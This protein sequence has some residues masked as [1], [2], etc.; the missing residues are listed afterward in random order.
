MNYGD[1]SV[2]VLNYLTAFGSSAFPLPSAGPS[3]K[4]SL[5]FSPGPHLSSTFAHR[6]HTISISF[7]GVIK[8]HGGGHQ[9]S[10]VLLDLDD[11]EP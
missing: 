8:R 7:T 5:G 3:G 1:F 4:S 11:L 9:Q 6:R 10:H 2:L